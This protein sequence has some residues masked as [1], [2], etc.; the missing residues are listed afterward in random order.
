MDPPH[1]LRLAVR[2]VDD[3]HPLSFGQKG[4]HGQRP[5]TAILDLMRPQHLERILVI[6]VD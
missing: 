1:R 5:P 4:P 3:P 2:A 6:N